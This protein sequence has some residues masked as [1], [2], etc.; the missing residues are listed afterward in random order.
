LLFDIALIILLKTKDVRCRQ[1]LAGLA[2]SLKT[3]NLEPFGW[4]DSS[5]FRFSKIFAAFPNHA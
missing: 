5:S 1:L 3:P 4:Q 2:S